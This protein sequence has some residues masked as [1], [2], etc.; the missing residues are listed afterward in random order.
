MKLCQKEPGPA[1]TRL[2]PTCT[3]EIQLSPDILSQKVRQCQRCWE[4]VK[5]NT[6]ANAMEHLWAKSEHQNKQGSQ[7][8]MTH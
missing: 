6:G 4:H 2:V 5:T 3:G 7:E 8:V 1:E